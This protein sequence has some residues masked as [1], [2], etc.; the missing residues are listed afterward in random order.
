MANK[1]YV[2]E[3]TKW[4]SWS[5]ALKG[6]REYRIN[7]Q[8]KHRELLDRLAKFGVEKAEI[9]FLKSNYS[10]TYDVR[11]EM[12]KRG[13]NVRA[14]VAHGDS[15]VFI[16]FGTGIT[17]YPLHPEA[18]A[19]GF[20]RGTYGQGKGANPKGWVY[21]GEQG[22]GDAKELRNRNG[23]FRTKGN[24]ANM[25]MYLTVEELKREIVNIISEVFGNDL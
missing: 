16:E 24:P 7:L 19:L 8:K 12:K 14:V 13:K 9:R 25:P 4:Q 10:G 18:D 23:V 5:N 17:Y 11:L 21:V 15:A 2:I 6:V 3:I 1:K 22:T 20:Q